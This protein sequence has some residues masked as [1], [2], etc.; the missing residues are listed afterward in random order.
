MWS[1]PRSSDILGL[2]GVLERRGKPSGCEPCVV[3]PGLVEKLNQKE[4][5]KKAL[6]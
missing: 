3:K 1:G 5:G 6:R 4:E 2:V